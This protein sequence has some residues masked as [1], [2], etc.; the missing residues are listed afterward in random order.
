MPIRKGGIGLSVQDLL[1]ILSNNTNIGDSMSKRKFYQAIEFDLN[2]DEKTAVE[3]LGALHRQF[4][5]KRLK[6]SVEEGKITPEQANRL[7]N[8]SFHNDELINYTHIQP[9]NSKVKDQTNEEE[10]ELKYSAPPPS[11]KI[12]LSKPDEFLHWLESQV[13]KGNRII[14]LDDFD[15]VQPWGLAALAALAR[16][17]GDPAVEILTNGSSNA[18][19]F[20][21]AIGLN[22]VVNARK[23]LGKAEQGRTVKM[24]RIKDFTK[25][26]KSASEISHLI[27]DNMDPSEFI[28]SEEMRRVIYYVLVE[29][30]RNVVQHS[31]DPLGGVIVAQSMNMGGIYTSSPSIQIAVADHG[32]GIYRTLEAMHSEIESPGVALE[33]SL[34]PHYSGAFDE[35]KKGSSQNAGLGLFFISEMAKLSGGR[36]LIASEGDTLCLV[37]DEVGHG[38]ISLLK[39]SYPGTLVVFEIPKRGIADFDEL[40]RSIIG[41]AEERTTKRHDRKLLRYDIAPDD[42]LE[43]LMKIGAEDTIVAEKLSKE[44]FVPKLIKKE[45]IVLNFSSIDLCTQSYAH[46]LLYDALRIAWAMHVP[47][48][49]K[50]ASEPVK[51]SLR[52]VEMYALSD[53]EDNK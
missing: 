10:N 14:C 1:P 6:T 38:A 50:Q 36:L 39:T 42:A 44:Y 46:A 30:M 7:W 48:Y 2:G 19:K 51:D 33:R 26:E 3:M 40:L 22:D 18:G 32:V 21:N 5:N 20:A 24:R 29:L 53:M 28:D 34:W 52:L 4:V 31:K 9:D 37:G 27:I 15:M 16:V 35:T 23:S 8:K 47:I 12:D 43:I 13:S 17:D 49:I 45:L 41:R 25:I 11:S